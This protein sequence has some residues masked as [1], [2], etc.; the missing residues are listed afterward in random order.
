MRKIGLI[1]RQGA[2][3]DY[4]TAQLMKE[5]PNVALVRMADPIKAV[6]TTLFQSIFEQMGFK[7]NAAFEAKHKENAFSIPLLHFKTSLVFH[8]ERLIGIYYTYKGF[9]NISKEH[10]TEKTERC[11][12][13]II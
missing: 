10:L 8:I 12:I 2:G 5:N 3:K 4:F 11:C 7:D 9:D 13:A 1:G 6:S